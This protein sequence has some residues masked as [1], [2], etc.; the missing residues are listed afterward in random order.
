MT[1]QVSPCFVDRVRR[2][3]HPVAEPTRGR[4]IRLGLD[5]FQ[6]DRPEGR[7]A[8]QNRAEMDPAA[9]ARLCDY[10]RPRNERLYALPDVDFTW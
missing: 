8:G 6:L 2:S 3:R 10:Y 4:R 1:C 5:E 9:A 7:N